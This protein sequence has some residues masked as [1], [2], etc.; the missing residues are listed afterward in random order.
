MDT[1]KS[2]SWDYQTYLYLK[3]ILHVIMWK[4][5]IIGLYK[6]KN[7]KNEAACY[8]SYCLSSEPQTL[9]ALS[10]SLLS[11]IKRFSIKKQAVKSSQ[12]GTFGIW[13]CYWEKHKLMQF[14]KV[15]E[16]YIINLTEDTWWSQ[17]KIHIPLLCDWIVVKPENSQ[18]RLTWIQ[19]LTLPLI[20]HMAFG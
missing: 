20:G 19:I 14:Q 1:K 4:L 12:E 10:L 17:F 16:K 7:S 5:F 15:M 13:V 3:P 2:H 9:H 8:I 11:I 6:N 18:I